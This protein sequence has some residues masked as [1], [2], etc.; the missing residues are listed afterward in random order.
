MINSGNN[1]EAA[2]DLRNKAEESLKNKKGTTKVDQLLSNND[3]L[4][5]IHEL[6]VHQIELEMQKEE[7]MKARS[8]AQEASEKYIELYDIAP[9]GYFTLTRD[10]QI[11]ELN[12]RG[13]NML[14]KERDQLKDVQ[15]GFFVTNETRP[16]FNIFLGNIFKNKTR[17]KESV[18]LTLSIYGNMSLSYW[19]CFRK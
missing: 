18:E 6:E 2:A 7:L 5:L 19:Y 16:A 4:K 9:S 17:Q 11:I 15:F 14:G 10:G 8:A 1:S 13:A 12:L 3:A